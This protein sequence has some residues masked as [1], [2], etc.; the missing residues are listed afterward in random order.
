MYACMF[1]VKGKSFLSPCF[2]L[3]I[4]LVEELLV[5][6]PL[7]LI[8]ISLQIPV[9]LSDPYCSRDICSMFPI[10]LLSKSSLK[11]WI[12]IGSSLAREGMSVMSLPVFCGV[13]FTDLIFFQSAATVVFLS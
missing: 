12:V 7:R 2:G 5:L 11:L 3:S 1:R 4:T 13:V 6:N 10:F 9:G 8:S